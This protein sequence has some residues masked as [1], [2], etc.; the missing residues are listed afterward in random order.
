[1]P[2][3]TDPQIYKFTSLSTAAN[4]ATNTANA[5]TP[6]AISSLN[7][8]I[9]YNPISYSPNA[10][11]S[12][13]NFTQNG[14]TNFSQ[15]PAITSGYAPVGFSSQLARPLSAVQ[16]TSQ[17]VGSGVGLPKATDSSSDF[18]RRIDE[19]LEQSR[20]QFPT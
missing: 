8:G 5:Q 17:V 20:R 12:T 19:Q 13:I 14:F 10:V 9:A 7:S 2:T 15:P 6:S 1:L 11:N 16:A 18:L 4:T 3:H